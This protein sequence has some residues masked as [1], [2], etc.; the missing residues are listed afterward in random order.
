MGTHFYQTSQYANIEIPLLTAF[1]K[2]G[3]FVN[4]QFRLQKFAKA[5][6]GPIGVASDI[7]TFA[8]ILAA[9]GGK[10]PKRATPAGVW[11]AMSAEIPQ[12]KDISFDRI[13][14][15]GQLLDG[16]VFA[17]E[18]FRE[19]KTLHYAPANA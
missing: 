12:F 9:M 7:E 5:V 14:A 10:A 11:E 2:D 13:P 15:D 1:E 3:T 4:Q 18:K 6:P 16:S 19:G 8:A 17:S